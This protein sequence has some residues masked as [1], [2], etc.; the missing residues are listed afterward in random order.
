MKV[1]QR[2]A[3]SKRSCL[4]AFVRTHEITAPGEYRARELYC[5][6]R[7]CKIGRNFVLECSY[8]DLRAVSRNAV[9]PI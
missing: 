5:F 7:A 1:E 2:A 8:F 9:L 6:N 3:N 4:R